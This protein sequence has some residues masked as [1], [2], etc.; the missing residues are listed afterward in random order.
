MST[1]PATTPVSTA[2]SAMAMYEFRTRIA[3]VGPARHASNTM[4]SPRT[5]TTTG[6][7]R[8]SG[9]AALAP[10]R[11]APKAAPASVPTHII[12]MS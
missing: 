12:P 10:K 11:T 9:T 7:L 3:T 5:A 4:D 2:G 8:R 6:I 1:D